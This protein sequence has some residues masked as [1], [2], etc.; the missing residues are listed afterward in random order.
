V[1][2][3]SPT[4]LAALLLAGACS[5]PSQNRCGPACALGDVTPPRQIAPLSTSRSTS[6]RPQLSWRLAPGSDGVDLEVCADRACT[7]SIARFEAVGESFAPDLDLPAG[8]VF[9]RAFGRAGEIHGRDPGPTW[10]L[11]VPARS[12]PHPTSW[13]TLPDFDGDGLA[14]V[15]VAGQY[16]D[17][18][19][20]RLYLYRGTRDGLSAT[21]DATRSGPDGTNGEFGCT[22]SSAGDVDGDGFADLIVG[23]PWAAMS[24]G[25]TYLYRGGP[26]GPSEEPLVLATP[27]GASR[28]GAKVSWAGDV[29]GDGYADVIV[30]EPG[31]DFEAPGRAWL[32]F[33]ARDGFRAALK[34]D[35]VAGAAQTGSVVAG[36]G[37]LDGDGFAD[38][39]IGDFRKAG[40]VARIFHGGPDG[41]T[42]AVE[43]PLPGGGV[44]FGASLHAAGD[45]DG[46]GWPD[47][48]GG[49]FDTNGGE[50]RLW[51]GGPDGLS[52]PLVLTSGAP[53]DRYGI[54]VTAAL[55]VDHDGYDDIL[56]GTDENVGTGYAYLYHGGAAGLDLQ[57][58]RVFA[59]GE[60]S[61]G[62]TLSG[63][64]D[65]DG[66]GT[67]D[68]IIGAMDDVSAFVWTD[69]TAEPRFIL[70]GPDLG[71]F[72]GAL[73]L[74]HL[75]CVR[76]FR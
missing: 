38:F 39:G 19:T 26:R 65:L 70:H 72:G 29:D 13:G 32:F 1:W 61:F 42:P 49:G 15:V 18:N 47:V 54:D 41:A 58:M 33:G 44:V 16:V 25:R 11:F 3:R 63:P 7:T 27:P 34:I 45:V 75:S 62:M 66:D 71:G 30:G 68:L 10:E 67:D 24:Q 4:S 53:Q 50:A 28:F 14:D 76:C 40:A 46:D 8:V 64:G 20:G 37:D 22:V 43:L 60:R 21:P 2:C 55:D 31:V 35:P 74:L 69:F 48:I 12:A 9:W 17:G 36:L 57:P 51:R 56:V 59:R 5:P 6:T 73:A 23:A 52:A